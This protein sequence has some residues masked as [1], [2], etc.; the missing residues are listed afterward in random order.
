MKKS[1][2]KHLLY[3]Q[4]ELSFLR[5]MGGLFAAKYPKIAKRLNLNEYQSTDPH[6]ERLIES[7]AYLTSYLQKDIDDQFPRISSAM[8]G[9]LYPHQVNLIPSMSIAHF[10]AHLGTALKGVYKV[11]KDSKLFSQSETGEMCRFR[12]CY[13][14]E[15]WPIE[16][17]DIVLEKLNRYDFSV[18]SL[19]K[20]NYAIKISLK[21]DVPLGKLGIQK[22]R[23]FINASKSDANILYHLLFKEDVP[24]LVMGDNPERLHLAPCGS[25][26]QVGF[27][28]D[29]NV[30]PS[31]KNGH[32]AYAL[33][34]EYFVF[35]RKF[36]FFDIENLVFDPES[37][38]AEI[39][40]PIAHSLDAKNITL[41]KH[42]F[43]LGCTPI[44][45]LFSKISEPIRLN[46]QKIDYRLIADHR[47]ELTTEVHS[48]DRVFSSGVDETEVT[49]ISPYF[50]YDHHALVS[51]DQAF[52]HARRVPSANVNI[53]GMDMMISFVDLNMSPQNPAVDVAYARI[54]CTNRHLAPTLGAGTILQEEDKNS[55][56]H[57]VKCLYQPT[58]PIYPSEEGETQWQ[59]ISQLSLNYLS[60]SSD[61]ESLAALKEMLLIYAGDYKGAEAAEINSLKKMTCAPMTRRF[62]NDAWRGFVKGTEVTLTIDDEGSPSFG[63]LLF[64]AVL[65]HFFGLYTAINSFAALTIKNENKEGVWKQWPPITGVQKLL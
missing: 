1:H 45:N 65:S 24:V 16:V 33:L 5:H 25:I 30:I 13:P 36:A 42:T 61:E 8:L 62:G 20:Y 11:E 34:Q 10:D 57:T 64:T 6:V 50:S 32:R 46:H 12:T 9:V 49:E 37:K 58:D 60:F 35:S 52:W 14:V 15:L 43:L 63:S 19:S 2:E 39:L 48:I 55:P 22:L 17:K 38:T 40:I 28:P 56:V 51:K 26:K 27:G 59:L 41:N 44:I 54:L 18:H 53:P 23:F 7:V 4:R 31:P 3:Y 21:A 29:E 47:R